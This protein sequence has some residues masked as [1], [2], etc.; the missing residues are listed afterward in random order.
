MTSQA[1]EGKSAFTKQMLALVLPIALQ[2]LISA[3][4]N[5]A[6]VV[7]LG[8]A[9]T[10]ALS[11]VSLA[12]QITFALTLFYFGLS[13]GAGILSAQYWG[14]G[15]L[16]AIERILGIGCLFSSIISL[17]FFAAA[18]LLPETL[19]RILT[20]DARLIALGGRYLRALSF[21]YL[22]M[23]LSQIY[24]CVIKSMER[25]KLSA[26][27][28]SVSLLLNIAGNALAI[29]VLFPGDVEG[30]VIGVAA[31]TVLA[32]FAEVAW[33]LLH[34]RFRGRVHLRIRNVFRPDRMLVKDFLR[35]TLPVQGNYLVWGGGLVAM[36]A[37]IG[38]TSTALVA[39]NSV[40][41]VVRNLALVLCKGVGQGG[42]VLIGK[43]LGKSRMD[44]ARRDAGRIVRWSLVFGALAGLT[45]LLTRPLSLAMGSLEGEA[46]ELLSGM[47]WIC[48]VYCI[49]NSVNS[50]V[51]SGIFCAGGDARFGFLCDAIVMWAFI[52]PIGCLLAFV[53]RV[54]PLC[55][56]LFFSTDE[57]VKLP[58]VAAH[59]R[60][61][62][63][64]KNITRDQAETEE[65][66]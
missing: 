61:Y 63:W 29:F 64:L 10:D 1:S 46:R 11:A 25:V 16:R 34:S 37:I 7:M 56:F 35:Y 19:M 39:A 65:A 41:T 36:S 55:L 30:S 5:S 48:A 54:P 3:L 32:R 26:V 50:A 53:A 31:S 4:V 44:D 18:L 27:I 59:Y 57:F 6:D 62:G 14:K 49:G 45:I 8:V 51:I 17:L 47:L 2:N 9:G 38:H 21:S 20:S 12:G 22:L 42:G 60:K 52:V 66:L 58:A 40:A 13:S 23:S 15:D 24:L 28:T 43:E 33:C